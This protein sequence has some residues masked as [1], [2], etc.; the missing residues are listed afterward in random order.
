M[1]TGLSIGLFVPVVDEVAQNWGNIRHL[2]YSL[3]YRGRSIRVSTSYLFKIKIDGKYL[4][5]RGSRYPNQ[6]QPVG[7]VHK[8]S[9]QGSAVLADMGVTDDNLI[10]LDAVSYGDLRLRV[11]GKKIGHFFRWFDSRSGREDSPWREFQEEL[12]EG[13][14][15]PQ[16]KFPHIMHNYLRREVDRIRYSEWADSLEIL[17]RDIYELVPNQEQEDALRQTMVSGHTDV[18]WVTSEQIKRRGAI[19]GQAHTVEVSAHSKAVL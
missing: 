1:T 12:L 9:P 14:I 18:I 11:P 15:L 17:V 7:G 8:R 5:I 10:P 13:G 6:F 19:P 2:W 16:G 4:L 3:R